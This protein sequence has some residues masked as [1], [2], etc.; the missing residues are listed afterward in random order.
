MLPREGV[1]VACIL[2][3]GGILQFSLLKK[4]SIV[5]AALI[6]DTDNRVRC[7]GDGKISMLGVADHQYRC[8]KPGARVK[9]PQLVPTR[10]S[11]WTNS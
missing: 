11:F 9:M 6:A 1:G 10:Q 7:E 5:R 4:A 8:S 2:I 3:I